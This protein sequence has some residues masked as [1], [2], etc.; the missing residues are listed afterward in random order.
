MD[1]FD[2]EK[3]KYGNRDKK[4]RPV[5]RNRDSYSFFAE[6][7]SNLIAFVDLRALAAFRPSREASALTP[8]FPLD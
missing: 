1:L 2:R 4:V 8:T 5:V 7:S 6:Q 3:S